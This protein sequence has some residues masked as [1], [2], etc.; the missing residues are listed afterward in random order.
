MAA[1]QVYIKWCVLRLLSQTK[2]F[3]PPGFDLFQFKLKNRKKKKKTKT[4]QHQ[5]GYVM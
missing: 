3:E 5:S 2:N 4:I 1:I